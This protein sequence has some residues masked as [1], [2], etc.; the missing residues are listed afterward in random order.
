MA[1]ALNQVVPWGRSY[2]EYVHMFDLDERHLN[3]RILGCADGPAAF[4]A[5]LTCRGGR[6]ISCDPLYSASKAEIEARIAECFDTVIEQ[7]RQNIDGFVWS[8]EIRSVEQLGRVRMSAMTTFLS[9]YSEGQRQGRYVAA[10][11]P[12]MPFTSNTFDLALCSHFLF[13][14]AS[15]GLDFHVQSVRSLLRIAREVRLFPLLQL[16]RKRS[17]FVDEVISDVRSLGYATSITQVPYE[18]QKGANEMLVIGRC[19]EA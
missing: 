7:T 15:L 14:Y 11:L 3:L 19:E 9:D 18:F 10:E 6:I 8:G 13:L 5:E 17:P 16:D 1:F 12:D 2:H 4:N